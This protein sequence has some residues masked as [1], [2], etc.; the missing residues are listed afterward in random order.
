MR[1]KTNEAL[2]CQQWLLQ[3]C[4]QWLFE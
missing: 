4:Q 2:R 1:K 3:H